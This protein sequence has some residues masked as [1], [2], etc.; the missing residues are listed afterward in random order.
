MDPNR[1]K[2]TSWLKDV[3]A[4]TFTAQDLLTSG[5]AKSESNIF[6]KDVYTEVYERVI[7]DEEREKENKGEV[8][9]EKKLGRMMSLDEDRSEVLDVGGDT[10]IWSV[11]N[12]KMLKKAYEDLRKRAVKLICILETKAMKI[13]MLKSENS[14][15]KQIV[16]TDEEE[17][18]ILRREDAALKAS[19]AKQQEI[20]Q[21]QERSMQ[22]LEECVI[23]LR[24]D[25]ARWR[26]SY[27][28][29]SK[30]NVANELLVREL[31]RK[32]ECIEEANVRDQDSLKRNLSAEYEGQ[33]SQLEEELLDARRTLD[34][35]EAM[36]KTFKDSVSALQRHF[37]NLTSKRDPRTPQGKTSPSS[38]NETSNSQKDRTCKDSHSSFLNVVDLDFIS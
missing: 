34:K 18:S 12:V 11:K 8:A 24:E 7:L 36:C 14:A 20:I 9:L 29:E 2:G 23:K 31:N 21:E 33:I 17:L 4:P 35:S 28:E 27:S 5:K 13:K 25:V 32:I 16:M 30:K 1:N 22:K 38:G 10:G 37:D 3:F 6:G 19:C 26:K 15:L